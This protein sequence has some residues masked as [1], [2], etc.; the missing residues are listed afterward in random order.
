[1]APALIYAYRRRKS[2]KSATVSSLII[3]KTLSKKIVAKKRIKLPLRFYIE[4]LAL[5]TLAAAATLPSPKIKKI[6]VIFDN[7]LSM[8]AQGP[9]KKTRLDLAIE[10]FNEEKNLKDSYQ[11]FTS[12]PELK[13]TSLSIK[14]ALTPDKL[15]LA[16]AELA[17]EYEKIWIFTDKKPK[18]V[19]EKFTVFQVGTNLNNLYFESASLDDSQKIKI[20]LAAASSKKVNANVV[21]TGLD[22]SGKTTGLITEQP[23]TINPNSIKELEFESPKS[24]LAYK[25]ELKTTEPDAIEDD[26]TA[27][28]VASD[29]ISSKILL[30]SAL[31]QASGLERIPGFSINKISFEQYSELREFK[32]YSLIIFHRCAPAT[33]PALPSLLI[34]PPSENSFFP[35][36]SEKDI[37]ISSWDENH[38]ISSY[39]RADLIN[40]GQGVEFRTPVWAQAVISGESGSIIA[41]GQ[42]S[43]ELFAASGIELLPYEGRRTPALSILTVN[44]LKW[45]SSKNKIGAT[46]LTGEIFN[47]E[48]GSVVI[49]PNQ[50]VLKM[51]S[52]ADNRAKANSAENNSIELDL[53]G[54]YLLSKQGALAVNAFHNKE[55]NTL[56]TEELVFP[57]SQGKI[58]KK[59]SDWW[60][61]LTVAAIIFLTLEMF[62]KRER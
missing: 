33:P 54:I 18:E 1:V 57:K 13:K 30:V 16:L 6:A 60:K 24:E 31:D 4:L 62:L 38:P 2:E 56:M 14:T 12:S 48:P 35:I 29:D 17:P 32:K 50:E 20:K 41:A 10:K 22:F 15:N 34:L 53:A 21:I 9:N 55:S 23:I 25:I 43:G 26:N 51:P 8:S 49:K 11:L 40:P 47:L 61:Y 59:Q 27:W 44:L 3:L 58:S 28:L 46:N 36:N 42:H 37:K 19:D 7:S 5:L 45:L 39:L 52:S